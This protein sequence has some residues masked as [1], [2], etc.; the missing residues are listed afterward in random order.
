MEFVFNPLIYILL[1]FHV[2]Q[3]VGNF[4]CQ[5]NY[6]GGKCS[7]TEGIQDFQCYNNI[8]SLFRGEV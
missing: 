4:L 8:E 1:N 7:V 5:I 3:K 6:F 2:Q